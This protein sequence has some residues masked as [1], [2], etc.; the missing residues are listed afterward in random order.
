MKLSKQEALRAKLLHK[1][2]ELLLNDLPVIPVIYNQNATITSKALS[3]V[4]STYYCVSDFQKTKM[5][6]SED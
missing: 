1:A 4:L 2:E 3:K 6:N 5:K